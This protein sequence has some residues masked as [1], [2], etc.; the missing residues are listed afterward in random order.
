VPP[1]AS[2]CG[3]QLCPKRRPR[4]RLQFRRSPRNRRACVSIATSTLP[5][6]TRLPP[7]SV[8][9]AR[10]PRSGPRGRLLPRSATRTLS[11]HGES[12]GMSPSPSRDVALAVGEQF[13]ARIG[14]G[15]SWNGQCF[16]IGRSRARSAR[17]RICVGRPWIASSS[18]CQRGRHYPPPAHMGAGPLRRYAQVYHGKW[19]V[20][21]LRTVQV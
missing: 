9:T 20:T 13:Y 5:T 10:S 8:S 12:E 15:A 2:R 14:L 3:R 18:V 4:L 1:R 11:D 7:T 19:R 21:R 16:T 6:K 17:V